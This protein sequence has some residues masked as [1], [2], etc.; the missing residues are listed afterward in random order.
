MGLMGF[1]YYM[2]KNKKSNT[3]NTL[4]TSKTYAIVKWINDNF[5]QP[6]YYCFEDKKIRFDKGL[7][8][9]DGNKFYFNFY[10]EEKILAISNMDDKKFLTNIDGKKL[11]FSLENNA[12]YSFDTEFKIKDMVVDERIKKC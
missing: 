11:V 7:M 10:G 6:G 5:E 8:R 9:V 4:N 1:G 3:S 12:L 2:I